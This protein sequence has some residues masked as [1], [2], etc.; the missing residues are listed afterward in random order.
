MKQ[1]WK[2]VMAAAALTAALVGT[3]WAA[4]GTGDDPVISLSYLQEKFTPQLKADVQ[5]AVL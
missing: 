3:V 4:G 2:R 5:Q 1:D